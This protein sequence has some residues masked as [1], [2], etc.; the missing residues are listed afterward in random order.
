MNRR[1]PRYARLLWLIGGAGL[2]AVPGC[3][4]PGLAGDAMVEGLSN[5]LNNLAEAGFLTIFL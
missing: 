1:R 3:I 2:A 5:A 4:T